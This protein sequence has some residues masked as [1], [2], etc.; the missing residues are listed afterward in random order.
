MTETADV[1]PSKDDASATAWYALTPEDVA[2]RLD[3]DPAAG[4]LCGEGRG[5]AEEER[6]QRASGRGDG[7][8]LEAVPGPVQEL[9]ADH[10]R[11]GGRRLDA[12][13]ARSP[14]ASPSC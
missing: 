6:A 1:P 3:V 5:A 8:R 14:R 10:P 11:R 7:A 13:S 4:P 2:K 12:R 9:H